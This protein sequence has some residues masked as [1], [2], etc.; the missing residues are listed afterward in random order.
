MVSNIRGKIYP[1]NN[2]KSM[3]GI[4]KG[5]DWIIIRKRR[6]TPSVAARRQTAAILNASLSMKLGSGALVHQNQSL[7][8]HLI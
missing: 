3:H 8:H 5:R 2:I 6:L 4:I 7:A 1:P